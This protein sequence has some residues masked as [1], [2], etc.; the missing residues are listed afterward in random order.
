VSVGSAG[1]NTPFKFTLTFNSVAL[2]AF[3]GGTFNDTLPTGATSSMIV[4]NDGGADAPTNN[5]GGTITAVNGTQSISGM[6]LAIPAGGT[7]TVTFYAEFSGNTP[8]TVVPL[9][10]TLMAGNV[11][12]LNASLN[13]V[14]PPLNAAA[15]VSELPVFTLSNYNALPAP[16][17]G[18]S[19]AN[20]P[21]TV[22]AAIVDNDPT[23]TLTD[24][25]FNATFNLNAGSVQLAPS[26]NFTFSAGCPAGLSSANVTP[27]AN[28]ESFTLSI[29]APMTLSATCTFT[30]NVIDEGGTL[31][32]FVPGTSSYTSNLTGGVGH[33]SGSFTGTNAVTFASTNINIT[34]A[35]TPNQIQAGSTSV[36][37]ITLSVAAIAGFAQTQALGVSVPDSLPANVSFASPVNVTFSAGCQQTGQP[38]PTYTIVGSTITA[39]NIS[40][41]AS[42]PSCTIGFTVTSTVLGAPVNIIPAHAVTSTSGIT[43]SQS[44]NASLTVASGVAVQKTYVS[45][46][47]QIGGTD[48]I[49]FL[50]TNS[51]VTAPGLSGGILT[52]NMPSQLVLASTTLG[53]LQPGDGALTLCGGSISGTVGT[54]SYTLNNITIPPL[55]GVTPG[56]CLLYVAVGA[57]TTAAPGPVTNTI[58]VGGLVIGGY[59]NQQ[60]SSGTNTLTP[61]PN[62]TLAKA[63]SPIQIQPGGT[64]T[65]TI[66]VTNTAAGAAP[67]SGMTLTDT[68]PAN[69]SIAA[70]PNASSNCTPTQVSSTGIVSTTATSVSLSGGTLAANASCTITVSVTSSTSGIWTNSIAASSLGSTQ[71]ATN[72]GPAQAVLN[73]GN[74]SGIGISKV[75]APAVIAPGATSVLTVTLANVANNAVA[76][77]NV[78]VTDPLPAGVTIAATPNAATTCTGGTATAV[79]GGSTLALSGASMAINASCTFSVNVTGTIS[80]TYTNTIP[81]SAITSAQGSTNGAPAVANLIIGQPSLAVVKTSLPSG[82]SVSPGQTVAYTIVVS[83]GGTQAETNAHITDTLTNATLVPG[84]VTVNG[85]AAPDAVV[86]SGQTFGTLAIGA[87]TTIKYSAVVNTSV[88][89]GAQVTNVAIAGGDQPCANG[90]CSGF[91]PANVV[92]PPVLTTTKV[93]D[94]LQN[95]PVVPGQTVTY[96][97]TVANSGTVPAVNAVI[98][99]DVPAGV[100]VVPNTVTLNGAAYAGATLSGQVLT[101][102]IPLLAAGAS[103]VVTFQATVGPSAGNASNVASVMALGLARA[104]ESNPAVANLVP[105]TIAVTKAASATTVSTGDRVD[106]KIV[107][108]SPNGVP[109]GTTTVVD[110][111]PDYELYAAGTARV[112]GVAQEPVVA[113]HVLTWT[114]PSLTTPVTITYSVA[115]GVGAPPNGTLTNTVAAT[116]VAPGGGGAGHGSA[117]ASVLV[118]GSTLG[119]CSPI[120]GR[121]YFDANGTGR[122]ADPDVGLPNVHVFLDDGESVTTDPYGRYDFPCVHPG[123]HALRLDTTTLPSGVVP[124][125]DRNIDS[126]KSTRRLVHHIYDTTI[127]EDINFAL[128][129]TAPALPARR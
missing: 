102:P 85:T 84:S 105:A 56:Q 15:T 36:A 71:G 47:L 63:F 61:A 76:L 114:L 74:V 13:P 100:T 38:A 87:S 45:N 2:G 77:T 66:T 120:T 41:D 126:E 81:A 28:G 37:G 108:S 49:R 32:T 3:T 24:S 7:C 123:M 40:L 29:P 6:N 103:S 34:K 42:Q 19:L 97:I 27:G 65:L 4:Y 93:I 95:K 88:A 16:Q 124:F 115:I 21:V 67:L 125:D 99:D 75:F 70:V 113:G 50:L 68:M 128:T 20:Q 9:T 121:V 94:G 119:S 33:P 73:V 23:G 112:A 51:A 25:N 86:T 109:F 35:F 78:A 69:V 44:V 26:P 22:Q 62:V 54:S 60:P 111:L 55:V 17:V 43:N 104:A 82:T 39:S 12:F 96:G 127:I 129:G 91:S 80:N 11:S 72:S 117:S 98:T 53:P 18:K 101:V 92:A 58:G 48:Y 8:G 46:T 30:Y 64:S 14:S 122:F 5:C 116:A 59:G 106:Y 110:T 90:T 107:V 118:V 89:T 79:A 31:G 57:S 10:N 83:N 1:P 52:D